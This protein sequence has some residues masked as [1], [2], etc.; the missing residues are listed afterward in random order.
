M[1]CTHCGGT[2]FDEDR[3]RADLVCLDCGMVLSENVICS[4]VEFVETSAGVSAAVGRFVSDESQAI[5]RESRQVTENRARRRIDTICGHLRLGNDIATSAF[6][7]YQSALFRG[8]TRGRGALQVAASCVYLAARQLRVNL[9]LLDLSDAVGIN[10]YVL[11]HC[12]TELRRRLHLSIPEMDPCLYIERFASQLEFGDKMPVVA[13]TAM[14]LLQRM[15]KDWLTTGRRPSGLAAAALLVAARIHEFNRNEEDVARIARI[16]QQTARKRLEEFGRTPTS[17][18]SIEDFFTVDYEEEQ[19]PPA[20]TSARK[21]DESVKEL[22]EA[23]FA[24]ISAEINELERRIDVELQSLVDKRS[25]RKLRMKLEEM[26]VGQS[27]GINHLLYPIS[28]SSDPTDQAAT[29]TPDQSSLQASADEDTTATASTDPTPSRSILRDVLDG[30]VEPSL[31]DSCVEDLRILTEHS[32]AEVCELL[33][34]AEAQQGLL[35]QNP[36]SLDPDSKMNGE[37]APASEEKPNEPIPMK[38]P[39]FLPSARVAKIEYPDMK[40][41]TLSLEGIDDEE[42]DQEYILHPREV[43]IKAAIWYKANAEYLQNARRKHLEKLRRAEEDAKNPPKKRARRT[44]SQRQPRPMNGYGSR[45]KFEVVSEESEDKP[46][47]RKINYEALEALVGGTSGTQTMASIEPTSVSISSEPSGSIRPGPLLASTLDLEPSTSAPN[48]LKEPE[49]PSE[50]APGKKVTFSDTVISSSFS[51][52][53]TS[54]DPQ[55]T[56]GPSSTTDTPE[57]SSLV[58]PTNE[59]EEEEEV[60]DGA[61]DDYYQDDEDELSWQQG[62][63]LW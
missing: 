25:S 63:E 56:A 11:G 43:M 50:T 34:Q 54:K 42:L 20:F 28:E 13:T 7:F 44:G 52:E 32:G 2:S 45:E 17:A 55:P 18:L 53:I 58:V 5:G 61:L 19:D 48:V 12:Y 9:M 23:S 1:R 10:V 26:E 15:K 22:D 57:P 31:L 60:E 47:S 14:R 41:G 35:D 59:D 46:F 4:E 62:D 3:A 51:S 49:Q 29:S 37:S 30:I 40:D 38:L 39:L 36:E 27:K 24:R 33:S 16:S 21:S 6:R 8:I